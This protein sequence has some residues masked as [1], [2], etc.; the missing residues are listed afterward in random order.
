MVHYVAILYYF[1]CH[2]VMAQKKNRALAIEFN[3]IIIFAL[4]PTRYTLA[5][6]I[7]R[8]QM[9]EKK[10]RNACLLSLIYFFCRVSLW[11]PFDGGSTNLLKTHSAT[12]ACC[13]RNVTSST[14]M[15]NTKNNHFFAHKLQPHKKKS[16]G[17]TK[18]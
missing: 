3:F 14:T 15:F 8:K 16:S 5:V 13:T 9:K 2:Y 11:D 10:T 17:E 4:A 7:A 18:G 12:I 1:S 6:Y